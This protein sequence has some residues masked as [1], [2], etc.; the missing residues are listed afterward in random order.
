MP[1]PATGQVVERPNKRGMTFALRFRALGERQYVTLGCSADGWTRERADLELA[2]VLAD[3]RRG[4]WRPPLPEP[5]SEAP[6]D[7]MFH[8]FA[9]EWYG[10]KKAELRP[11]TRTAYKNELSLHLLPFF[12]G[13]RLSQITVQEV[14]RYRQ[15]QL[16]ESEARRTAIAAGQPL[17]DQESRVLR[18]SAPA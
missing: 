8:E 6:K 17:L 16:R 10:A 4:I 7:P 14:D 13:H 1:R 18:R 3:V 2:N 15:A 11:N 12:A 5:V 9:S